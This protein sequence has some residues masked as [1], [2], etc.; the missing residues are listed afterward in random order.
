MSKGINMRV[1]T[2]YA[3]PDTGGIVHAVE[4]YVE[5]IPVF[6]STLIATV[7]AIVPGLP[8][9]INISP[10]FG[11]MF[12]PT[13]VYVILFLGIYLPKTVNLKQY[14]QLTRH[15]GEARYD[16]LPK[17]RGHIQYDIALPM[18][19]KIYS[20]SKGGHAD[21]GAS[22]Y[23]RSYGTCRYCAKRLKLL[24]ELVPDRLTPANESDMEV[25]L[26]WLEERKKLN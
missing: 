3:K 24:R 15:Y 14:D 23:Q 13:L 25:A 20:C 8:L 5:G 4:R 18:V 26:F 7:L 2:R 10:F 21:G 22:S 1:I 12:L 9:A 11:L 17:L 6:V 16:I 19:R